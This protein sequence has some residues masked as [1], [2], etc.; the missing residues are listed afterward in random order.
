MEEKNSIYFPNSLLEWL[1]NTAK[2]IKQISLLDNIQT[3][4]PSKFNF[5]ILP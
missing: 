5:G 3:V 2:Y 4:L 1:K